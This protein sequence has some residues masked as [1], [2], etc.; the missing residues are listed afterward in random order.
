MDHTPKSLNMCLF[1][2]LPCDMKWYIKK[3]I[4]Y[5][6]KIRL[7]LDNNRYFM[8]N[9]NL[10]SILTLDQLRKATRHGLVEKLYGDV[11]VYNEQ[12]S[13]ADG[14]IRV[15]TTNLSRQ[16]ACAFPKPTRHIFTCIVGLPKIVDKFHPMIEEVYKGVGPIVHVTSERRAQDLL[17]GFYALK[18]IRSSE[19]EL[20]NGRYLLSK[21]CFQLLVSLMI[22]CDVIKK[23]R[24]ERCNRSLANA[25]IQKAHREKKRIENQIQKT[26]QDMQDLDEKN[27][28]V[29]QRKIKRMTTRFIKENVYMQYVNQGMTLREAKD[30]L[31]EDAEIKKQQAVWKKVYI[32]SVKQA[33]AQRK[34]HL[35]EHAKREKQEIKIK[36]SE[37][38]KKNKLIAQ[39]IKSIKTYSKLA[40]Q[41]ARIAKKRFP[42]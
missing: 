15:S 19:L 38:L 12:V 31:K 25:A 33:I 42:L 7:I 28:E 39:V 37:Q 32:K 24:I 21:L 3:F 14:E 13:T 6:T 18:N 26:R 20:L 36:Q 1:A 41:T 10:Y 5:D 9:R 2:R 34:I 35:K 8:T 30:K 17:T 16:V 27:K 4:D 22:Y 29:Y 23:Y 11:G 40:K